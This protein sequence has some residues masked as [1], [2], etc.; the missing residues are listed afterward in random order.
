MV[1][2]LAEKDDERFQIGKIIVLPDTVNGGVMSR[3]FINATLSEQ[4]VQ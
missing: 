3:T 1:F 2:E 4:S